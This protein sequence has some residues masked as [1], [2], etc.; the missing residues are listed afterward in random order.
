MEAEMSTE[1]KNFYLSTNLA[2]HHTPEKIGLSVYIK[3]HDEEEL[4][5]AII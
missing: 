2:R 5:E 4:S 1:N 3:L